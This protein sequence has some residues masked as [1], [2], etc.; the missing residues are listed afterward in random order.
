MLLTILPIFF[1]LGKI[2]GE[3]GICCTANTTAVL[4]RIVE[5]KCFSLE[6]TSSLPLHIPAW[7]SYYLEA[8]I[9][10]KSAAWYCLVHWLIKNQIKSGLS[11]VRD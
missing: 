6:L 10:F 5:E 9:L 7:T 11:R 3:N 2:R 8:E 1:P 4:H